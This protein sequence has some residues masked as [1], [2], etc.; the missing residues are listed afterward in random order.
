MIADEK[1][2]KYALDPT[3]D[4]GKHRALVFESTLGYNLSNWQELK[5]AILSEL[6][7]QP[8]I[9]K[10]E[11]IYGKRYDVILPITG[12]SGR[13][14]NVVTAWQYDRDKTDPDKF[15]EV[16]RLITVYVE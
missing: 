13:T 3:S 10:E 6:P 1:L 9:E 14:V 4:L 5:T 8:C 2:T 16:P 7:F 11:T 15:S 12:P